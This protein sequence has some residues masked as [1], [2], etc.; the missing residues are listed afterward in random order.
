MTR[1]LAGRHSRARARRHDRQAALANRVSVTDS[2]PAIANGVVYVGSGD[3][4]LYAFDLRTGKR[5]WSARLGQK[6][7]TSSPTFVNGSVYVG[8]DD[9]NVVAFRR[10]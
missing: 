10:R 7:V 8:S 1:P 9:G 3:G 2:A 4:N 5:L 6:A